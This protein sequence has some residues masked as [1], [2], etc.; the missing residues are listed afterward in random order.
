MIPSRLGSLI[1]IRRGYV[2]AQELADPGIE[3]GVIEVELVLYE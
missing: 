3:T 1:R 2:R